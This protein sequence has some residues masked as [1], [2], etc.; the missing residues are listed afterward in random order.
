MRWRTP[1]VGLVVASLVVPTVMLMGAIQLVLLSPFVAAALIIG[2]VVVS[3]SGRPVDDRLGSWVLGV[4]LGLTWFAVFGI[5]V[6]VGVYLGL[7]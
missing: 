7:G 6:V 1:V 4:T 2:A 5:A 3:R